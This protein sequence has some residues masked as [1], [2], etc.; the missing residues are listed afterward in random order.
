MYSIG[1]A[2]FSGKAII[3]TGGSSG[4][5]LAAAQQFAD[6]GGNV[7]IVGRHEETIEQASKGRERIV[8]R[9]A[10]ISQEEQIGGIVQEAL[11]R[12]GRI[13]VVVNNAVAAVSTPLETVTTPQITS[14]LQTNVLAPTWLNQAALPALIASKGAIV[15]ISSVVG[16]LPTTGVTFYAASKAALDHLTRCWARELAP[17]G[18][19][20]NA[21]APGPTETGALVKAGFSSAQVENIRQKEREAIPFKQLGTPE[22]VAAWIVT[23][24]DP[25]ST[26]I[27]GQIITVDGGLE[28]AG[29]PS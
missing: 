5:G 23:L 21:V 11:E 19:R 20:V 3:I 15:N 12:W 25:R 10:D 17:H 2:D 22:E 28:L 18:I 1:Q 24:A 13:D 9:V 14:I 8:G 27:T 29:Y 16:H 7:L 26:W 6:L 4:I